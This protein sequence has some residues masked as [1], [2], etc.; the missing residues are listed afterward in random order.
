MRS[1][2]R[3]YSLFFRSLFSLAKK[4]KRERKRKW[5][6]QEKRI[7]A[8]ENST[9]KHRERSRI[10]PGA[11][12]HRERLRALLHRPS[13]TND[14]AP[15]HRVHFSLEAVVGATTTMIVPGAEPAG[16]SPN[17]GGQR[18]ARAEEAGSPVSEGESTLS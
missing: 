18:L 13:S 1:V 17:N 3:V 2:N 4:R 14:R 6:R 10:P 9:R 15:V 8:G 12:S 5:D 7:Q 11:I 16:L